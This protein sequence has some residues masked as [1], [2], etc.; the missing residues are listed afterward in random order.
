MATLEQE[1]FRESF[2]RINRGLVDITDYEP[3]LIDH[4]DE[5][6]LNPSGMGN[7]PS[8]YIKQHQYFPE[9]HYRQ[10]DLDY[11]QRDPR[12][13]AIRELSYSQVVMRRFMELRLHN[14]KEEQVERPPVE[15]ADRAVRDYFELD[16]VAA[17][18]LAL[19]EQEMGRQ[20][21]Y[22]RYKIP[23]WPEITK[24]T[25]KDRR[26]IF[27]KQWEESLESLDSPLIIPHI[28]VASALKRLARHTDSAR[29]MRH[30]DEMLGGESYYPVKVPKVV[31]LRNIGYA[32]LK[33]AI[34]IQT[35]AESRVYLQGL[36]KHPKVV[37]I[38]A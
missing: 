14:E 29:L 13:V 17:A 7:N 36:Q 4:P 23:P 15:T 12:I 19:R 18:S 25:M 6:P 21:E 31:H 38:A 28:L 24:L 3:Y 9:P 32:I 8:R 5:V 22:S 30:A 27:R 16:L 34:G 37:P 26:R 20:P 1:G 33:D 10:F 11:E 35:L 2:S